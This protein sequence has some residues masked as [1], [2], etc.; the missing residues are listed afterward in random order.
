MDDQLTAP[1]IVMLIEGLD[2]LI[3]HREGSEPRPEVLQRWGPYRDLRFSLK[4]AVHMSFYDDAS[5]WL[6]AEL[7][8]ERIALTDALHTRLAASLRHGIATNSISTLTL[9]PCPHPA[10]TALN[11]GRVCD[12]AHKH[13]SMSRMTDCHEVRSI[14]R[15][16][17]AFLELFAL[18]VADFKRPL[19]SVI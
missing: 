16:P 17:Q 13:C 15:R 6:E 4:Q 12:L 2:A 7:H 14:S 11:D 3:P 19:R 5:G 18:L 10:P 1:E 8:R 9:A